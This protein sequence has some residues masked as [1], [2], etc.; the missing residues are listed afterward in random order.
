MVTSR[1]STIQLADATPSPSA[2]E[3]IRL[4]RLHGIPR[5]IVRIVMPV[6]GV[7]LHRIPRRHGLGH[8]LS[9]LDRK[10][11][12]IVQRIIERIMFCPLGVP[13]EP[14]SQSIKFA[15]QVGRAVLGFSPY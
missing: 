2:S 15:L 1:L 3:L 5:M 7:V 10:I 9:G 14:S 11:L 6:L 13:G 8:S 12:G 4:V